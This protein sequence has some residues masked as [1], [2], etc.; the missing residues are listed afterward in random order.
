MQTTLWSDVNHGDG[1]LPDKRR[2][3]AKYQRLWDE[4][5]EY[6]NTSTMMGRL[7]NSQRQG[8]RYP[9]K[10]Y[11][12]DNEYN[13]KNAT[14][15]DRLWNQALMAYAMENVVPLS[16]LPLIMHYGHK[17]I[18]DCD[19]PAILLVCNDGTVIERDEAVRIA[20]DTMFT[21]T[22]LHGIKKRIK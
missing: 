15:P 14:H 6:R 22:L 17:P 21:I 4:N 8:K 18:A 1:E 3:L 16:Q 5:V 19:S 12:N 2:R 7:R 9:Y 13:R 10:S 20:T 11:N